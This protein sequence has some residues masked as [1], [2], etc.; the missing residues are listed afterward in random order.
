[1]TARATPSQYLHKLLKPDGSVVDYPPKDRAYTLEEVQKAV[2]GYIEVVNLNSGY[3]MVINE[4]GKLNG[5][6]VNQ[7]ATD[8]WG[9]PWDHIVGNAL[10][11]RS[12]GEDID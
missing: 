10:V 4:E 8:L 3:I 11:C 1:M 9:S 7:K 5:L 12:R 2:G 6:P